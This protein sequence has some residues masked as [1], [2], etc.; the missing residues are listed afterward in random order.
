VHLL[1]L[2]DDNVTLSESRAGLQLKINHL[3]EYFTLNDLDINLDKTKVIVFRRGGKIGKK[4]KFFLDGRPIAVVKNYTYLGIVFSSSGL[5]RD[6]CRDRVSRAKTALSAALSLCDSSKLYSWRSRCKIF[7]SIACSSLLYA[8]PIWGLSHLERIEIVQSS[9]LK[10]TLCAQGGTP[11][12]VIRCETG[13]TML[14]YNVIGHVLSFWFR[15]L[16]MGPNRIP[17]ICYNSFLQL[18]SPGLRDSRYNWAS[19]VRNILVNLGYE[20][21]WDAQDPAVLALYVTVICAAARMQCID[22]DVSRLPYST[23]NPLYY[24][25]WSEWRPAKYLTYHIPFYIKKLIAQVRLNTTRL[26]YKGV[27]IPLTENPCP[28]C[29]CPLMTLDHLLRICPGLSP[30]RSS[31]DLLLL[32]PSFSHLLVELGN[33]NAYTVKS[34][35]FFL[36]KLVTAVSDLL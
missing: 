2:A 31:C 35:F 7:D 29:E 16:T 1:M 27:C 4:E 9:F 13:R 14:K 19:L 3:N 28:L 32:S 11:N 8:A 18:Q 6:A 15:I 17:R 23:S 10:R 22:E 20:F 36:I 33:A 30:H 34:V 24:L 25:S 26:Y 21:I 5:F 12:Y